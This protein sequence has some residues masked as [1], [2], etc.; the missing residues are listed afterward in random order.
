M[1]IFFMRTS[2]FIFL[3]TEDERKGRYR[4]K[5]IPRFLGYSFVGKRWTWRWSV[6]DWFCLFVHLWV[7]P[8]PLEDCSVFGNFVITLMYL[9]HNGRKFSLESPISLHQSNWLMVADNCITHL[10][11]KVMVLCIRLDNKSTAQT[12]I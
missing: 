10:Q 9:C 6:V 8:F 1:H 5:E 3:F 7:L 11:Y 12:F 4:K 2:C